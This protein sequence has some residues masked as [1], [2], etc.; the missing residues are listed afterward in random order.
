MTTPN[1]QVN[2]ETKGNQKAGEQR[3]ARQY[4]FLL[5][6]VLALTSAILLMISYWFK[7]GNPPNEYWADFFKIIGVTLIPVNIVSWLF[8]FFSAKRLEEFLPLAV[9]QK[10][11]ESIEPDLQVD[12]MN[13]R[14]NLKEF[15][16]DQSIKEVDILHTNF[17]HLCEH[18]DAF[19]TAKTPAV[20]IRILALDPRSPFVDSRHSE[21][22]RTKSEFEQEILTGLASAVRQI[23]TMKAKN[24]LVQVE[25]RL[26]KGIPSISLFRADDKLLVGHLLRQASSR[27]TIHMKYSLGY[28]AATPAR[29]FV[30]HFEVCWTE[31][32]PLSKID[33][34][35]P[36]RNSLSHPSISS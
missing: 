12:V 33:D 25:L 6:I 34:L 23:D 3:F 16:S 15:F 17:N 32:T 27:E 22:R 29:D 1:H 19:Q 18:M 5:V 26:L 36:I 10:V 2:L 35:T 28:S 14:P 4:G 9:S 30:K 7:T 31:G 20:K 13:S 21:L 11:I 8:D 24:P